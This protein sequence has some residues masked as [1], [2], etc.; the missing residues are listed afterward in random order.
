MYNQTGFATLIVIIG[1]IALADPGGRLCPDRGCRAISTAVNRRRC[2]TP[3]T[4]EDGAEDRIGLG[5]S[6]WAPA[7]QAWRRRTFLIGSSKAEIGSRCQPGTPQRRVA[8]AVPGS[9]QRKQLR[10]RDWG[11]ETG[12]L[13]R[14]LSG[15]RPAGSEGFG[16][17]CGHGSDLLSPASFS[18]RSSSSTLCGCTFASP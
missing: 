5:G 8:R 7:G 4:G 3:A 10:F 2:S 6:N 17:G 15:K 11:P 13:S 1:F 14:A 16:V 18:R 9:W 12:S